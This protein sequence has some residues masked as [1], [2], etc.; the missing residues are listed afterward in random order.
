MIN[1]PKGLSKDYVPITVVEKWAATAV[2]IFNI[3][4]E[5]DDKV[6]ADLRNTKIVCSMLGLLRRSQN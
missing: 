3:N 1:Q 2:E 6:I 5:T 4:D